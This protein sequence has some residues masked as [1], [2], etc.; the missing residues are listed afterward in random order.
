MCNFLFFFS[1][2]LRFNEL[3]KKFLRN[4][5]HNIII[6]VYLKLNSVFMSL[7]EQFLNKMEIRINNDLPPKIK[8]FSMNYVWRKFECLSM[9]VFAD[10]EV[11]LMRAVTDFYH[12]TFFK[13]KLPDI[14][15][16][17]IFVF[18]LFLY[19]RIFYL[20]IVKY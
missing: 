18:F 14:E 6:T 20:T 15:I 7:Y 13:K 10:I 19:L 9:D 5:L 1:N 12:G 8:P 16:H 4:P 3:L 17:N 11:W 2:V